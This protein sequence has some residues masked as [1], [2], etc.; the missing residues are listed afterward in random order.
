MAKAKLQ[1]VHTSLSLRGQQWAAF[2][3]AA[4][5]E[6]KSRSGIIRVWIG[7]YLESYRANRIRAK[8]R[9]ENK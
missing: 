3:L 7:N 5:E 4:Q 1:K 8:Q 6:G 9:E 2:E